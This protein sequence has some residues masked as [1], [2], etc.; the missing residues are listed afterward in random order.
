MELEAAPTLG[1]RPQERCHGARYSVALRCSGP[2]IGKRCPCALEA[3]RLKA[4]VQYCVPPRAEW[5]PPQEGN[6]D[7]DDLW[8]CVFEMTVPLL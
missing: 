1:S 8:L 4:T 3:A 7:V 2:V 5:V 6:K